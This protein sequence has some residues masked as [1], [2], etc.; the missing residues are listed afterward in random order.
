MI[1]RNF[2]YAGQEELLEKATYRLRQVHKG[3]AAEQGKIGI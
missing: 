1:D 3:Q 2:K